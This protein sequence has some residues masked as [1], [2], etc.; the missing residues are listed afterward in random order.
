MSSFERLM[1][2]GCLGL[3]LILLASTDNDSKFRRTMLLAGLTVVGQGVVL[4]SF[5]ALRPATKARK[6]I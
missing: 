2:S 4:S 1:V 3:V 6:K 5:Q